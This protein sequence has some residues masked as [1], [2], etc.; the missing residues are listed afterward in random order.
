MKAAVGALALFLSACSAIPGPRASS[1]LYLVEK[2]GYQALYR[3]DGRLER[4]AWDEDGDRR[5]DAI[6]LYRPD[7]K[8]LRAEI[9]T[10][11]D[12]RIDRREHFDWTGR[13]VR[14]DLG[15]EGSSPTPSSTGGRDH[16]P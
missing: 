2:G 8:P 5:A 7:G 3:P 6:V 9:D 12:G 11:R 16:K 1:G 10:D 14:V 13:V 4:I 15:S